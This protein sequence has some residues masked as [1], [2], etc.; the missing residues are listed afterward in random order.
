MKNELKQALGGNETFTMVYK[1]L[2]P[3]KLKPIDLLVLSRIIEWYNND[4]ICYETNKSL[5][6][7][8]GTSEDTISEAIKRL[9]KRKLI[10]KE[11]KKNA[12]GR[13]GTE[14]KLFLNI[15]KLK[16]ALAPSP[17]PKTLSGQQ[18]KDASTATPTRN[19]PNDET[20][21]TGLETSPTRENPIQSPQKNINKP[22]P[23][24]ISRSRE[25][26]KC[27][28]TS[29]ENSSVKDN[30]KY[31]IKDNSCSNEQ[32]TP[33]QQEQEPITITQEDFLNQGLAQ[34]MVGFELDKDG[35]KI[36]ESCG[37]LYKILSANAPSSGEKETLSVQE[38]IAA[39]GF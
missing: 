39:L 36:A 10:T 7:D 35:N 17:A 2:F 1:G 9:E 11:T 25:Q 22:S 20:E 30:I 14:R 23:A 6:E 38:K 4:K 24:R 5:S 12:G 31:N 32:P 18:Q 29:Q 26:G 28:F 37:K 19:L 3:L 16:E 21:K 34:T 27:Q 15:E 8:F 13:V 33:L